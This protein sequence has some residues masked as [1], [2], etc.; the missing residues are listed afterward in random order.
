MDNKAKIGIWMDHSVANLMEYS[1]SPIQTQTVEC[2]F[3]HQ[4]KEEALSRG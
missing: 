3:D 4:S 1:G 2:A